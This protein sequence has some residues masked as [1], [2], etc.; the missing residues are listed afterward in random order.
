MPATAELEFSNLVFFN[1]RSVLQMTTKE[2]G[3]P[4]ASERHGPINIFRVLVQ[5][6]VSEEVKRLTTV[7]KLLRDPGWFDNMYNV[8]YYAPFCDNSNF[9]SFIRGYYDHSCYRLRRSVWGMLRRRVHV[10]VGDHVSH[11]HPA[12][13]TP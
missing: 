4:A 2:A 1:R 7:R 13:A 10:H 11:R 3:D 12:D 9:Q 8:V 5:F 6:L